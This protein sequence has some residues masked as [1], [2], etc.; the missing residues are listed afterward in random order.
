MNNAMFLPLFSAIEKDNLQLIFENIIALV[1]RINMS[2]LE[3]YEREINASI[4]ESKKRYGK[5]AVL[6]APCGFYN[7]TGILDIIADNVTRGRL[8]K[9][10]PRERYYYEYDYDNDGNIKRIL[11]LPN[12]T[13]TLCNEENGIR[14]FIT[15]KMYKDKKDIE[16]IACAKFDDRGR[17]SEMISVLLVRTD[18]YVDT[19]TIETYKYEDDTSY[20]V[21]WCYVIGDIRE[22]S[23]CKAETKYRF[24]RNK[25]HKAYDWQQI[26]RTVGR[27]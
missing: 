3:L 20:N 5:G 17:L 23:I 4:D 1:S 2:D 7:P 16:N 18:K 11:C 13:I 10:K 21:R 15:L 6:L 14:S 19:L 12:S 25:D 24:E 9:K 27:T 22:K 26:S 8:Y